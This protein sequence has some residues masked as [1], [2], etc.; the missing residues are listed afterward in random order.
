M[1]TVRIGAAAA[2]FLILLSPV[3]AQQEHLRF[4]SEPSPGF[5]YALAYFLA[6]SGLEEI[7]LSVAEADFNNDGRTDVLAFAENSYYCGSGGCGPRLFLGSKKSGFQVAD[8][9]YLSSPAANWYLTDRTTN[10]FRNAFVLGD[11]TEDNLVWDGE[12]YVLVDN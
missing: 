11:D 2:A 8:V 5:I 10:G 7:N 9:H 1:T 12:A 4:T 3:A 6:D